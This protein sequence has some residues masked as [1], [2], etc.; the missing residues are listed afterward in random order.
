MALIL[1]RF[2]YFAAGMVLFG[3]SLFGLYAKGDAGHNDVCVRRINSLN[4]MAS[5]LA[6]C[7]A[8]GWLVAASVNMGGEMFVTEPMQILTLVLTRTHFGTVWLVA[9]AA[10]A[11]LVVAV[12]APASRRGRASVLVVL[13]GMLLLAA[14]AAGH[15]SMDDGVAGVI[16]QA[17]Q[18][19]H[20]LA[21]AA[22]VGGLV[23]LGCVLRSV[24]SQGLNGTIGPDARSAI[25]DAVQSLVRFSAVGI[26]AVTALVLTGAI[27]TWFMVGN[28][29]LATSGDY[30]RLLL[31]KV[32]LVSTMLGLAARNRLHWLPIMQ[33][34]RLPASQRNAALAAIFSNVLQ[35]QALAIVV[36][37]AASLLGTLVPPR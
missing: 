18:A 8:F 4:R 27:N 34:A 15:G 10:S 11:L 17:S 35:E 2:L 19:V 9:L 7:S 14:A 13:S 5:L 3:S 32:A 6:L 12:R 30:G 20:M 16:H 1:A 24:Q 25:A 21:A 33:E 26:A 37:I 28:V 31:L 36:L 23:P 22:W 29:E